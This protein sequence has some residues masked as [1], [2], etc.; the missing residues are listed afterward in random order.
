MNIQSSQKGSSLIETIIALFVMAIGVLGVLS[1]QIKSV[2]F[3]NNAHLYT[4]AS[5]LASDIYEAMQSTPELADTYIM[6]YED[7][8]PSA[9]DCGSAA[10]CSS[11]EIVDWNKAK[12]RGNVENLLPSGKSEISR[13]SDQLVIRIEYAMGFDDDG[14]PQ[15]QEFMLITDI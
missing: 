11:A 15:T 13:V 10:T 7:E 14:T 1:M 4:Q 12:W 6:Y 9:T 2:Q 8:A 3:N 5:L